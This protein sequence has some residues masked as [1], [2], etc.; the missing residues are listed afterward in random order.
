MKF[1]PG[2]EIIIG[3]IVGLVANAVGIYLYFFFFL[4]LSDGIRSALNLAAQNDYLG[5]V[6]ALG[7]L[8]NLAAFFI[9]LRKGRIYRARGVILATLLAAIGILISK[10]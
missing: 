6:I 4:D 10:F 3:L 5:K 7:A 1:S 8:L 2:I 9:F